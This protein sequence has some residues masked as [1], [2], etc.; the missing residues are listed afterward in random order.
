MISLEIQR[1]DWALFTICDF[2]SLRSEKLEFS[3]SRQDDD[4]S[5]HSDLL[6]AKLPDELTLKA[7]N[8]QVHFKIYKEITAQ[9]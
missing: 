4:L 2:I 7:F 8:L 1:N 6:I 3:L 9:G 5:I